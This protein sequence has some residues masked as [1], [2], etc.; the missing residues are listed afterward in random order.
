MHGYA[1]AAM[2]KAPLPPEFLPF[3]RAPRPA[4]LA[5]VRPDG[6][7]VTTA[8]WFD[9]EDGR[10]LLSM[11]TTGPRIRNV[12]ANPHVALTIL[13]DSWYD[14]VSVSG[15]VVELRA[16]EGLADLDRLSWRYEGK[17]YAK[18]HLECVTALVEV[19]RWHCWG[20]P[21]AAGNPS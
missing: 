11:K 9:W 17:P 20:D 6:T 15:T 2:P 19:E 4:V 1:P 3:V 21:A 13:G 16:D 5:T 12:R 14:H 18:R 7:P 8:S 10:L